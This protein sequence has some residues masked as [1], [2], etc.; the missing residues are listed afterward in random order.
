MGSRFSAE[1]TVEVL[2]P[3]GLVPPGDGT[4]ITVWR[5]AGDLEAQIAARRPG[6]SLVVV[7]DGL[8]QLE[9]ASVGAA[10]AAAGLDVIEVRFGRWDGET[11]SSLSAACR[12]VVAGFGAAGVAAVVSF[13][14]AETS[15]L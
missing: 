12:A 14:T 15:G 5:T 6:T 3:E 13:L 11:E 8:S 4:A 1:A 7:S 2:A 10:I 9:A